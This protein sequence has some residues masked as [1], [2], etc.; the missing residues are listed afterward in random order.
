MIGLDAGRFPL[1][2]N[3]FV[4]LAR[5][6]F[7]D[8]LRFDRVVPDFVVQG[9]DPRGNGTGGPGY[10]VAEPP[11][12]SFRYRAGTVAMGRTESE[13]RGSAGSDFFIVLGQGGA[14][15]PDYAVLGRVSAG[16]ATVRRIG[17]LGGESESPS[18]VVRIDS[19]QIRSHRRP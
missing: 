1:I 2:V 9:G 11:P 7:Y 19:I 5:S 12:P 8:G 16:R 15:K 10:R 3:S 13:P 18:Q 14:I 6:G 17:A 4:Y